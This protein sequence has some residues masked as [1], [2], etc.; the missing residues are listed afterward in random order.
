[1]SLE[2]GIAYARAVTKTGDRRMAQPRA[3]LSADDPR[4]ILLDK[5]ADKGLGGRIVGHSRSL[6]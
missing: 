2:A 6:N 1:M 4:T 3:S 5:T